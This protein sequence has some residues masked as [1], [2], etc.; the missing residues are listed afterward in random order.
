MNHSKKTAFKSALDFDG[1]PMAICLEK[2]ADQKRILRD[3]QTML[4][5]QIAEHAMHCV[6][7]DTRLIIYTDSAVWASQIRFF[8]ELILNKIQGSGQRKITNMQIKVLPPVGPVNRA[9]GVRVPASET[10]QALLGQVNDKSNDA[11]DIA[12]TKLAKTLSKRLTLED[13]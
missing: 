11:L 3:V 10:V 8:H 7:S 1:R 9:R 13:D 4:P 6:V 2:I 5:E 12:L